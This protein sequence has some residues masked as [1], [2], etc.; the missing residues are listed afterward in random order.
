MKRKDF[1]KII[2]IMTTGI[3]TSNFTSCIF[4][5]SKSGNVDEDTLSISTPNI[6]SIDKE[7][8]RVVSGDTINSS[9]SPPVIANYARSRYCDIVG[10]NAERVFPKSKPYL[11]LILKSN[12]EFRTI[13]D[14]PP[15]FHIG[16]IQQESGFD[17]NAVSSSLAVGIAQF[18]YYTASGRKMNVYDPEKFPDLFEGEKRLKLLNVSSSKLWAD[19]I[20]IVRDD[21]L[22]IE[23]LKVHKEE[24]NKVVQERNDLIPK[25]KNMCIDL[26]SEDDE[27][28]DPFESLPQSAKYFAEMA[29]WADKEYNGRSFHSIIR[30]I[31]AYNCGTG[32]VVEGNGF[33]F[34][35]ESI[36]Y[37][38]KVIKNAD[39]IAPKQSRE[40]M[41]DANY[42]IITELISSKIYDVGS[43]SR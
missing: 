34:I 25:L 8:T 29:R 23:M 6:P 18:M 24:Y 30:G 27:R 7:A 35:Q 16:M 2:P 20:S 13:F 40:Y 41:Y 12:T 36:G 9:Y 1:L 3:V 37:F 10:Q 39:S 17:P 42:Q 43:T 26:K 5:D 14:I 28:K 15:E 19:I 32:N 33:P 38:R 11:E 31:V 21:N 4:E 22:D